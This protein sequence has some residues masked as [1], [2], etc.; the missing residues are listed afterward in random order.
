MLYN[1]VD[2]PHPLS[3]TKIVTLL[4]RLIRFAN[5]TEGILKGNGFCLSVSIEKDFIKG[6]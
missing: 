1:K 4:S 5:H 3:P 6:I 2:L